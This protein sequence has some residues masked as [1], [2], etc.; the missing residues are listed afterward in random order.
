MS[1]VTTRSV[2]CHLRPDVLYS[3]LEINPHFL[4]LFALFQGDLLSL[5][6]ILQASSQSL[7]RTDLDPDGPPTLNPEVP[8]VLFTHSGECAASSYS[9]M[10]EVD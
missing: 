9:N 3:F 10:E 7:F 1:R 6:L 2:H 8:S 4:L 5:Q